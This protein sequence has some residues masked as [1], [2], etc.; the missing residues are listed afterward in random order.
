MFL[1]QFTSII[2]NSRIYFCLGWK[3]D[4]S[5]AT[6]NKKMIYLTEQHGNKGIYSPCPLG[7]NPNYLNQI[8]RFSWDSFDL[9]ELASKEVKSLFLAFIRF[10]RGIPHLLVLERLALEVSR[11][12]LIALMT[13]HI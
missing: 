2:V 13:F 9:C 1:R 4:K 3:S 11:D 7:R 5:L 10:I 6:H 8:S 12:I